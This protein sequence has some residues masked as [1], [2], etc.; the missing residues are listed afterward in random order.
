MY[1]PFGK[2]VKD[3]MLRCIG[4]DFT[5]VQRDK[6]GRYFKVRQNKLIVRDDNET[7]QML[8]RCGYAVL[9]GTQMNRAAKIAYCTYALT[10]KGLA[11]LGR[12]M[13]LRIIPP[14]V[15]EMEYKGEKVC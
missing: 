14:T 9:L 3:K 13:G 7:W 2:E 11:W 4:H 15:I 10:E 8:R 12:Q 1:K 5:K 6:R